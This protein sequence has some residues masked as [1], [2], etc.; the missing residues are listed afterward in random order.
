MTVHPETSKPQ[1]LDEIPTRWETLS[2]PTAFVMRY[3]TAVR[4][5]VVAIVRDEEL[6]EEVLQDFLLQ[7]MS[8]GFKTVDRTRGRFR[9]YLKVLVRNAALARLRRAQAEARQTRGGRALD[10]LHC[11]AAE[12]EAELEWRDQWRRSIL[13]RAWGALERHQR[14]SAGNLSFAVLW[15]VAQYPAEN[16]K[17]L[18]QRA[19]ALAGAPVEPDA[20]RKQLSRARRVFARLLLREVAQTLRDPTPQSLEEELVELGLMKYV[21]GFLPRG[22]AR[23]ARLPT[24]E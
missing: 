22:W 5:Y 20:F 21:G 24:A 13:E 8:C 16:S 19:S 17:A 1:R 18:S 3:A 10:G 11:E 6:A 4:R 14:K 7:V 9:D 15:L 2:E 12:P 23:G